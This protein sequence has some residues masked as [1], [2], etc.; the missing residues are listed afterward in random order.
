MEEKQKLPRWKS[1]KEVEAFKIEAV[2]SFPQ[3]GG[4][5]T[6]VS[7]GDGFRVYVNDE[8]VKKHNPQIGGYYVRYADGYE[9]F[10]PAEAFEEGYVP[11]VA[12][13]IDTGKKTANQV[14]KDQM[15]VICVDKDRLKTVLLHC[16]G[17]S[18]ECPN[19]REA[20]VPQDMAQKE[21]WAFYG[22]VF[23]KHKPA[24]EFERV[25]F[26]KID[27]EALDEISSGPIHPSRVTMVKP[28]LGVMPQRIW[29]EKR[30][31]E[32]ARAITEY[33]SAPDAPF[34]ST[35]TVP[36][37]AELLQLVSEL[38]ADRKAVQP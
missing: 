29:K 9:S 24:N 10:S 12:A 4:L 32:L 17:N 31:A 8:Y 19:C 18:R 30:I 27:T 15:P 21:A 35:P 33:T 3:P 28:P 7:V 23:G 11:L 22:E 36:W 16:I 26:A 34:A 2:L 1:H 25:A 20:F 5:T 37:V 38:D 14:A 13:G 6:L